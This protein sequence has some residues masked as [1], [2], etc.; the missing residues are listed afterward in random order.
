MKLS[1]L[2]RVGLIITAFLISMSSAFPQE[3]KVTEKQ[4][5]PA[6]I[7][8][9]KAAYPTASIRGYSREKEG[10]KVYYEIESKSSDGEQAVDVLYNPDGTVAEIEESIDIALLP[11]AAQE[12]LHTTYAKATVK[13]VER[14]TRD[15][16]I[17]YEV[18][19]RVGRKMRELKFD[20][21][22]KPIR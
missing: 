3:M 2:P 18:H 17:I 20:A 15:N 16:V 9:F 21:D 4:V 7:A 12:S 19:A 10:G 22:G 8:A 11:P 5:P 6:V 14:S 1:N 13:T